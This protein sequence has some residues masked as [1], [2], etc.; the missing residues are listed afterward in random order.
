MRRASLAC[1]LIA[2][3]GSDDA[4]ADTLR[5]EPLYE[6][7]V[8]GAIVS[9]QVSPHDSKHV[10][11]GGDM[12][13]T[14]VSF[15]GGESWRPGL[16]L[17]TYEMATATFHPS[18]T[19]EVWIG[20]CSGPYK[21]IDGGRTWGLKR[22]GMP[23]PA[24]N[25]YTMM[26]EKVLFDPDD[27]SRMLAFSGSSRHW[28]SCKGFGAVWE[29]A[30]GG[31]SWRRTGTVAKDGWTSK[32]VEGANIVRAF[33]GA[34]PSDAK[35]SRQVHL[36][37][38]GAGWFSS[39]DGGRTWHRRETPGMEGEVLS[40]TGHPT[41]DRVFWVVSK[42]GG[43]GPDGK[44]TPGGIYKTIDGGRSFSPSDAGIAK[45][46]GTKVKFATHFNPIAVS[47]SNP[48]RLYVGDASWGSPRIWRSDD[49]GAIWKVSAKGKDVATSGFAGLSGFVCAAPGDADIAYFW[50]T[51]FILRTLDGGRTW[52]DVSS[53][54]P[55]PVG[56]PH[57]WRG[58]GW[59]G[60]CSR[61]IAFNPHRKGQCAIQ[62]MDACHAWIS[63][64]GLHT[65]HYAKG[66]V[67]PWSGGTG[68]AFGEG[69]R[70]YVTT[71]QGGR[72]AGILVS[73]DG[74]AS[75][76]TAS[77]P[78]CGLPAPEEG[79]YG[80]VFADAGD[81]RRAFALMEERMFQTE[82]GGASW[83]E[84]RLDFAPRS[85][86]RDPTD[87]GRWYLKTDGG[88]F[89]TR[90]W[91]EFGDLGLGGGKKTAGNI[92]CDARGRVLVCRG[93]TADRRGLWR[94]DPSAPDRGWTLLRDEPLAF[95]CAADPT[96]ADRIVFCTCD[97][98]YHDMAGGNG[99]FASEDGGKTWKRADEGLP[100][101]R[102][103]CI[104]FDPFDPETVVI[105][106]SGGGFF[107]ARWRKRG[108]LAARGGIVVYPEYDARIE[109]DYAYA[110]RVTQ[111]GES[112]RLAVYNHCEKSMLERRTRGG[113]V[114]RRFCEFAFD[115]GPVRVDV[116]FCEDVKS[117]A[118]FPSR[119]GLKSDFRN[120]V[121]SVWVERPCNFG[122]RIND[123]DKTILSVFA[124]A[125]EDVAKVPRKGAPGVLY[126]DGWMDPPGEDGVLTVDGSVREVYIAP[127]AVLN[128]R[129]VVK[130]KGAYIHGRGMVLDP[131]SDVFRFDQTKNTRR[132]FLNV[133]APGV[134]VEDVKLVDA[135]TF[136]YCS[137]SDDV[138]FRNVKAL[139]TMMCSD[140][141][142]RGGRNIRVDG[143]WLYVGDNALV[144]G[145]AKGA[146]FRDIAIGTSCNA[147]FPQGSNEGV[148]MEN[149]DVF[150]ADEGLVKN[151]YNGVLRR[152]TKWNEMNMAEA[153]KEP[154]PQDLVHRR[155]EFFFRNLSAV[156]CVLFSRFF[157]G[158]NMG[159]LPKTFGFENL[160]IPFCTGKDDWRTIGG[161]GG[162]V[163]NILHDSKRWLDTTGYELA[164]TNFWMGGSRVD[165]LP[166]NLVQNADRV[167][168]TV[169]NM[170]SEP[171]IPSAADRHEANWTCPFKRYIG[172]SLQRDV[173][174]VSR[175]AGEQRIAQPD[176]RA[177][178]LMDRASTRSAWQ[179]YPSWLVKFDATE[180]DG[181]SRVYR[182]RQC[183][184]G[185]GMQNVVTDGFL[186]QGCG[187][188]RLS[189]EA[190]A[191]GGKAVALE[192]HFLSNEKRAVAKFSVPSDGGWHAFSDA[193]RIDFD[194]AA[195]ELAAI[196]FKVSAPVD[197]LCFKNLSLTKVAK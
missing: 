141:I 118:V 57:A 151:V 3:A 119:I 175:K 147:I 88:V 127:G 77:G 87:A 138:V 9:V 26:I 32:A 38:D 188:Y 99:V 79:S 176:D 19:N 66:T 196:Q 85:V 83:R 173:R 115:G 6:P 50:N 34:I 159:T 181:D 65:W 43:K 42:T 31:E 194:L 126:V 7:G 125:P 93:R 171:A 184:K 166:P 134:T 190:R 139:S 124:D 174:K 63:D 121:L 28:G 104:A 154:G 149:V 25:R 178:L 52:T 140:G 162:A 110:V 153:K 114:N 113:D 169:A 97:A 67:S 123:Y 15:D 98:P 129:L 81:S 157:V 41:D 55:D 91:R 61:N 20:S 152:N 105:G 23:E 45:L 100:V 106:T 11:A 92:A 177:N 150:R 24:R 155:Q 49:G 1:I 116:A 69:G 94:Y 143:A 172:A 161:K 75:W 62:A 192:A 44:V 102:A 187:T 197:E 183:E 51:E 111:G 182:L 142:S 58:R 136:N 48:D 164:I 18:R 8:G 5:W 17:A 37:A 70:I 101:R 165:A 95:A 109:R 146:R 89:T 36:V 186:R 137:W 135:R 168:V 2:F 122:I 112:K 72:N 14:G 103:A 10:V 21:S 56:K 107:R 185:A 82:N 193:L 27:S 74:G 46:G 64:D 195:T 167:S 53:L 80:A 33:W 60:W 12:L 78:A 4:A 30:D 158:G 47:A 148:A 73:H 96:D 68:I 84:R 29:S 160:S 145:G 132:G 39:S 133:Y 86:V 163:V 117:Y 131:F 16:G 22:R 170:S 71:G 54:R 189:F 40:V 108:S 191:K 59:T 76:E 128:S 179:R 90:D 144:V 35:N 156:D 130:S 13:G 120:G 180:M